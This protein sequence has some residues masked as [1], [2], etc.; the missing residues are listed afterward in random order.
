[1]Q[2]LRAHGRTATPSFYV[3]LAL[4]QFYQRTDR[5]RPAITVEL[6]AGAPAEPVFLAI[7]SNT[8]P[9]TYLGEREV[10]A[11]PRASFDSDLDIFALRSLS[12]VATF[13][14]VGQ[15]L[16]TSAG[17]RL[18]GKHILAWH[19]QPYVRL[20]SARPV[21]FQTDGEYV[22]ERQT[23]SCSSIRKALRIVV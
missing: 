13:S 8:A 9:W 2:G 1:V 10:Q 15:M 17:G 23:V 7:I 16:T 19:D 12:S 22:G 3:R 20:T 6:D 18:R 5:T 4:R 14:A 11:S 21:A